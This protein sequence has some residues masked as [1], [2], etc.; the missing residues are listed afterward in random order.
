MILIPLGPPGSGKGTQAKRVS[1]KR[2]LA[3]LSTGDMFRSAI[4]A[5][6]PMGLKAKS[7]IDKGDLVPDD[8]TI[9]LIADRIQAPDCKA[10]F[11]LD[12]FPRTLPQ[13][14]AL[15][16][17]LKEKGLSVGKVILFEIPDEELV[18][19]LTGRRVCGKCG[20][21]Y[22]IA[23]SPPKKADTCDKCG[24]SPLTQR[25]DDKEDVIRN[26][27]AVYHKQ[28]S[29]LVDFYTKSGKLQR[30]DATRPPDQVQS[31]LERLL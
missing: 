11:I 16:G 27:L 9:G 15:N 25:S 6:T 5:G 19:R 20:A 13:A 30:L 2:G 3:H 18:G 1:D 12:G 31:L 8:V 21:M 28:T 26:R 22:H 10:G 7:F 23:A 24:T 14:E 17:L 29:P 4:Q